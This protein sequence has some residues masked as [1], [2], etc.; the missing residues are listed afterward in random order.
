MVFTVHHKLH[1]A[2]AIGLLIVLIAA[3]LMI[4]HPIHALF[5]VIVLSF[6]VAVFG[7]LAELK[8]L[9]KF[10]I[11]TGI[12]IVIINPLVS[13]QGNTV[14]YRTALPVIGRIRITAESLAFAGSMVLRL[15]SM[16]LSIKLF[17]L[18]IDRDDFFGYLSRY[19][20]K[21]VLTMSMTVNMI[22]RL[23][24]ETQ[25]VRE[26]M[27]M[28]GLDLKSGGFAR[29]IKAHYPLIKVVLI[30][31]LEGS[32]N[33]AEALYSRGYGKG[34]RSFYRE[35]KM[36]S[37]D[38]LYL[39]ALCIYACVLAFGIFKGWLGFSY[40][41]SLAQQSDFS[42]LYFIVHGLSLTI[43]VETTRRCSEWKFSA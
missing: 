25:R 18:S 10:W 33:R 8:S 19:M 30:S 20:N 4:S 36:E 22:H 11:V 1:P 35:I 39:A 38:R 32:V 16:V 42:S 14:L 5:L 23:R 13:T 29:R 37:K 26:V 2:N 28:R 40:F 12:M 17:G 6:S 34:K 9:L 24:V 31:S 7:G 3:T 41:P 21:L 15:F 43:L 27:E